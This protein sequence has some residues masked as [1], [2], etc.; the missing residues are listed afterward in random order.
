MAEPPPH[1]KRQRLGDQEAAS[2]EVL[3]AAEAEGD[4]MAPYPADLEAPEEAFEAF[5]KH[6]GDI[7]QVRTLLTAWARLI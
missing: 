1:A 4:G 6:Q 7:D 2:A 3:D 5:T